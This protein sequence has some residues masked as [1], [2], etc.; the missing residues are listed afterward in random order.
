M[1]AKGN[2]DNGILRAAHFELKLNIPPNFLLFPH[3]HHPPFCP[4]GTL[5]SSPIC[6]H[7]HLISSVFQTLLPPS[8]PAHRHPC[9]LR[10]RSASGWLNLPLLIVIATERA[11]HIVPNVLPIVTIEPFLPR[12]SSSS[13][14]LSS[15]YSP[16]C[17]PFPAKAPAAVHLGTP[18]LKEFGVC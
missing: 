4:S 16:S 14:P 2:T 8:A 6:I 15:P 18:P 11:T 9:R 12:P 1:A 3:T 5:Y 10:T 17:F 7:I 13:F